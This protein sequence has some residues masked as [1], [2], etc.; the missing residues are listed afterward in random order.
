M[1]C[2]RRRPAAGRHCTR[3]RVQK[4]PE[5]AAPRLRAHARCLAWPAGAVVAPIQRSAARSSARL[6]TSRRRPR[7][8][9]Q[10]VSLTQSSRP[11]RCAVGR[12]RP[13]LDEASTV[14]AGSERRTRP[15]SSKAFE[16]GPTKD[17]QRW[18]DRDPREPAGACA[19][20]SSGRRDLRKRLP[21]RDRSSRRARLRRPGA[22]ATHG[23]LLV[24]DRISAIR[25]KRRPLDEGDALRR[26]KRNGSALLGETL[27]S[28]GGR[29]TADDPRKRSGA[30]RSGPLIR[31]RR[32]RDSGDD[33][34]PLTRPTLSIEHGRGT[35]SISRRSRSRRRGRQR[36]LGG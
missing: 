13:S 33:R 17:G 34:H 11:S 25:I 21:I 1:H 9:S 35:C 6:R 27:A 28:G 3:E 8:P 16:A 30:S 4:N 5:A 15:S 20:A 10:S 2:P 18:P 7:R 12:E 31:R 32:S 22:G 19:T 36:Y 24:D 26:I 29:D 14:H 23:G